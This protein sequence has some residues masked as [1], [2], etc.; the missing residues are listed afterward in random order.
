MANTG[1]DMS[2]EIAHR[3]RQGGYQPAFFMR[4]NRLYIQREEYGG[5]IYVGNK[6]KNT[7][8]QKK[9]NQVICGLKNE[10]FVRNIYSKKHCFS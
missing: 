8:N 10:L 6:V 2:A 1:K 5:K 7:R 9:H 3:K 4:E